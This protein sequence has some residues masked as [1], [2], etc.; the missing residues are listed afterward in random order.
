MDIKRLI[1]EAGLDPS[2]YVTTPRFSGSVAFPAQVA[3]GAGLLVGYDPLPENPH[4]GEVWGA[5]RP[6]RF[7]GAQT[8]A[9]RN[10]A[11]WFVQIDNVELV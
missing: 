5:N 10:A 11:V 8:S 2:I 4:H 9:L 6:N 1:V 3:R 7:S